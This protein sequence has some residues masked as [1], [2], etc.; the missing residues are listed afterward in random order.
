MSIK[1]KLGKIKEKLGG[2]GASRKAASSIY[3]LLN[4]T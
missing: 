3:K 1:L 2:V 4:E